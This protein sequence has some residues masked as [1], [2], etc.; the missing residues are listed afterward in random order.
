M[1]HMYYMYLYYFRSLTFTL[2][3]K[4]FSHV[5]FK[6]IIQQKYLKFNNRMCN[7]S[8]IFLIT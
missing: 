7:S 6:N 1:M 8:K 5:Q 2:L 4:S 3:L